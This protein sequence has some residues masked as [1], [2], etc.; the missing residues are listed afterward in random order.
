VIVTHA[1]PLDAVQLQP[2]DVVTVTVPLPPPAA[3]LWLVGEI[4]NVQ[5]EP[6]W[7]TVKVCPA[8]VSVPVRDVELVLAVTL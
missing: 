3:K 5:D 7:V 2:L 6:G 1:A 4:V 8:M